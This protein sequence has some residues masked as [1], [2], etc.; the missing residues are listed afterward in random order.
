LRYQ[1]GWPEESSLSECLSQNV[2]R[3]TLVGHSLFGPHRAD[4]CVQHGD[5]QVHDILSQ[6]QQKL[7][8][9]AL[10]LAQGLHLQQIDITPVYLIDDLPSELDPRKRSLVLKILSDLGAQSFITGI[11]EQDFDEFM[12][13]GQGSRMF[14]VKHGVV[15]KVQ[16]DSV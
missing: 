12:D 14:H 9:Y 11:N 16:G 10:L 13:L 6:G 1:P 15:S 2:S 8:A 7:T 5:C 4:L 3:E